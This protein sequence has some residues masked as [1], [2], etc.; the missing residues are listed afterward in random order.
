MGKHRHEKV[1]KIG[2]MPGDVGRSRKI[3]MVEKGPINSTFR[4]VLVKKAKV[5]VKNR[6]DKEMNAALEEDTR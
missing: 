3:R 2:Q 6:L 5:K 4:K 1:A